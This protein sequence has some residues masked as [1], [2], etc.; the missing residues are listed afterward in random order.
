MP[1][2]TST[3]ASTHTTAPARKS[4]RARAS[5]E[6]TTS[7]I[8]DAAETL[9]AARNPCEVTMRDVA[10][11]AGVSH[12]LVHQYVGTKN[13]LLNAVV[14]RAAVDRAALARKSDNLNDALQVM[15]NQILTNRLHSKTL[16][17]SSMDGVEYM[18]LTDRVLTGE[19]LLD[20]AE[21]TAAART[22]PVEPPREL[23]NRVILAAITALSFGWVAIESWLWPIYELE[24][25]TE[26]E[27]HHQL[28]EIIAYLTNLTLMHE[29]GL[30][31]G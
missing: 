7:V 31:N 22:P 28:G 16:V 6:E 1:K 23:S 9:F 15:L 3:H 12:A 21:R 27:V 10:E 5:R 29:D 17:R 19:A 25:M 11:V 30:T 20:L 14:Q 2:K 26:D 4:P 8:L 24:S 13:D 18:D